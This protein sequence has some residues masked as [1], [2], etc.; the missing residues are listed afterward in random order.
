MFKKL[1]NLF[2]VE[3]ENSSSTE[4]TSVNKQSTSKDSSSTSAD[5]PDPPTVSVTGKKADAKFVDVL[6]KSIEAANLDGFDYLEYK[7]SLQSLTDMEMDEATK[8]KSAFAMAKTMGATPTKLVTSA[9]HYLTVLKKEELK[10]KEALKNQRE[11]QITG[12]EEEI[13]NHQRLA[14]EKEKQIEKLKKEIDIHNKKLEQIKSTINQSAAKVEATNERFLV[15]LHLVRSQIEN[16][17][18]KMESYLQ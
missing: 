14:Q 16:D 10:F 18:N 17:M 3:D 9:K 6:L 7:Q 2:V 5:I 8:Y 1:K 13:K 12:K 11:K 4:S 15:A